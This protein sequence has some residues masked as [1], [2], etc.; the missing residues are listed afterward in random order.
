[1]PLASCTAMQVKQLSEVTDLL[2]NRG[3][4]EYQTGKYPL[5]P[6]QEVRR[7]GCVEL[8][9]SIQFSATASPNVV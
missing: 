8:M 3:G 1:M 7:G 2:R 9:D 6:G 4:V 5:Q